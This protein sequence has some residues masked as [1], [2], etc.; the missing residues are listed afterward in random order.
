MYFFVVFI[1]Y[2]VIEKFF[3][4]FFRVIENLEEF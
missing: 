1:E 3:L 4:C 2:C